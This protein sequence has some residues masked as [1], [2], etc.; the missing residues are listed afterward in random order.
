MK[1]AY[2]KCG[3]DTRSINGEKRGIEMPNDD[4]I[5][6]SSLAANCYLV[7]GE[8]PYLVDTNIS[9]AKKKIIKA[10]SDNNLEPEDLQ[11]ILIT[12]HH[13]DHTGSMAELKRLSG[14]ELAAGE[15]DAPVIDGSQ[16]QPG[17]GDLNFMG[18]LMG[19]LPDSWIQ[20]YQR[21]DF[22][23]VDLKVKDGD[24]LGELSL[25]VLEIPG[26]TDGGV[27]FY[28]R[29]RKRAFVGDMITNIM[30]RRK[31]PF[32]AFSYDMDAIRDS[33]ARLAEL[34][35]E[36]AF[37]GHGKIIGPGAGEKIKELADKLSHK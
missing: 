30:N 29:E 4:V 25:E 12:H 11:Y 24:V 9:K 13:A 18:R 22:A 36:Y 16:E 33:I 5:L 1:G 2:D 31:P 8:K 26:H 14:A 28:D 23:E 21:F 6:I 15:K 32:L 10:L 27:A 17:P 19:K 3:T 34:D 20:S 37:P 35:L 7:L